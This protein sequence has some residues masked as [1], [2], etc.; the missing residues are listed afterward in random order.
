MVETN[1]PSMSMDLIFLQMSNEIQLQVSNC[2]LYSINSIFG[3]CKHRDG[4]E[5]REFFFLSDVE[6]S[7]QG[8]CNQQQHHRGKW[9][10][11]ASCPLSLANTESG[12]HDVPSAVI[13]T[14]DDECS[15]EV[16]TKHAEAPSLNFLS[17]YHNL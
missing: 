17:G 1:S 16:T 2:L 14:Q 5:E 15:S 11:Y 4:I 10:W 7:G 3:V 12:N 8:Q 9:Y 13:T 6:S